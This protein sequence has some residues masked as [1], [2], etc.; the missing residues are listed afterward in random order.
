MGRRIAYRLGRQQPFD[1]ALGRIPWLPIRNRTLFPHLSPV[2]FLG[3]FQIP[4]THC[5]VVSRSIVEHTRPIYIKRL[6]LAVIH[7]TLLVLLSEFVPRTKGPC[8]QVGRA[9]LCS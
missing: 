1:K 2:L 5:R 3:P 8:H 4:P 7:Q 9:F 6:A